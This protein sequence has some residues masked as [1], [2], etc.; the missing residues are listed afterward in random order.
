M[1]PAGRVCDVCGERGIGVCDA[2]GARRY[3]SATC[4]AADWESHQFK[5]LML[6]QMNTIGG[7]LEE[8]EIDP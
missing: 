2:C 3:C 1:C 6:L 8:I 4:Q 7:A 5:C